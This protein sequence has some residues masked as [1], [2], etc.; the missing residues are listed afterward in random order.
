[1]PQKYWKWCK[2]N[3][4]DYFKVKSYTRIKVDLKDG[5]IKNI[6]FKW[7]VKKPFSL[8]HCV[9]YTIIGKNKT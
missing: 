9:D 1:M 8:P 4:M 2:R 6:D 5:W 7:I 3:Y